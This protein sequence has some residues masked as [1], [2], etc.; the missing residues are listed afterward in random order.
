MLPDV[1]Q[2]IEVPKIVLHKVP[3]RS[4]LLQPQT[5][6][7]LVEVPEIVQVVVAPGLDARGFAAVRTVRTAFLAPTH[8][9]GWRHRLHRAVY[10]YW[11]RV[12]GGRLRDHARQVPA[13]FCRLTDSG[14]CLSS[15]PRQSGGNCGYA[16]QT[17]T[18]SAKL[19]TLDWLLTCP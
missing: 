6:E 13:V 5:A 7:Q 16:T 19:C 18:H 10:K 15:V 9:T 12:T 11:A 2:V 1:G 17:G 8:D 4:L 14:W 3:Q